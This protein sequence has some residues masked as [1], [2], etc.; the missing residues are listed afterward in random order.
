[1]NESTKYIFDE[2]KT[3][4]WS[5]FDTAEDV[6][7]LIDDMLSDDGE[8]VDEAILRAAV[9]PEFR[10]KLTAETTWPVKTDCDHLD[11]A[12]DSLNRIGIIALHN[13]GVT[14]SDGLSDVGE[15]LR[16]R[17]RSGITGYCFYHWQDIERAVQ[18]L[19]LWLAFGDLDDNK[20]AK[21]DIGKVIKEMLER[22]ALTVE[23][24]G[25]PDTRL[26]IP[27]FDWKRRTPR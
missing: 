6:H 13:A 26:R 27:V 24:D 16:E 5:G 17:G 23:W 10:Q 4:V 7:Q 18:G 2:I 1:M 3:R 8:D 20:T 19:G 14:Q 12:F 15:A 25:N 11:T 9:E 22:N 21:V